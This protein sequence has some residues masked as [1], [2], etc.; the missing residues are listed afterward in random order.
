MGSHRLQQ[1][2]RARYVTG[3]ER[4]R[5][6]NR[7]VHMALGR[8]MHHQ[9]RIGL[10]QRSCCGLPLRQVNAPE[11][12]AIA[13]I[14]AQTLKCGLDA[15]AIAGVTDFVEVE[16]QRIAL[17]QQPAHHRTTNKASTT[18]DQDPLHTHLPPAFRTVL[19]VRNRIIRSSQV[20]KCRR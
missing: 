2:K 6:V 3:Q 10:A 9:V 20:L 12:V 4:A 19:I 13:G 7:S 5:A 18:G 1:R 17:R 14:R 11:A 16:H 15:T 8:Q